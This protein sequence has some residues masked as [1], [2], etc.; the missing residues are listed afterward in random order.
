MYGLYSVFTYTF[1]FVKNAMHSFFAIIRIQQ[2]AYI[3]FIRAQ[4][5]QNEFIEFFFNYDI[6]YIRPFFDECFHLQENFTIFYYYNFIDASY[7]CRK[8]N[9][10]KRPFLFFS[11]NIYKHNETFIVFS[12]STSCSYIRF[13][14][15]LFLFDVLQ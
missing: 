9:S 14:P 7:R 1:I 6:L 8:R 15:I 10:D 12:Y 4:F 11:L 13:S 5:I 2:F 3:L